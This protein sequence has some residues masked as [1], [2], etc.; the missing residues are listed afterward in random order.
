MANGSVFLDEFLVNIF[1]YFNVNE[2]AKACLVCRQWCRVSKTPEL[3]RNLVLL[4]WPS[5]HFLYKKI[6]LRDFQW[7][8]AY[9]DLH[10]KSWFSPDDMK[11]FICC[12]TL[13]DELP[14]IELRE[15]MFD[16]MAKVAE[17]WVQVYPYEHDLMD[18][19]SFDKNA[20]LYYDTIQLKWV[21]L[22]RRRLYMRDLFPSHKAKTPKKKTRHIRNYQVLQK[23]KSCLR[24]IYIIMDYTSSLL[25]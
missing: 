23:L 3:W 4:K 21:F 11:Y 13:E 2:L 12:K 16:Q 7:R 18:I 1:H 8:N 17:K 10:Q 19:S 6:C 22:D 24:N 9:K 15:A 14:S 20:E 5:Q 25:L